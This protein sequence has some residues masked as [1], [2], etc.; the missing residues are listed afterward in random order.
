ML[1]SFYDLEEYFRLKWTEFSSIYVAKFSNVTSR[2]NFYD[3]YCIFFKF[4]SSEKTK[5]YRTIVYY[6]RI[7]YIIQTFS[8]HV[9]RLSIF[10][11]DDTRLRREKRIHSMHQRLTFQRI[12]F[13]HCICIYIYFR[14]NLNHFYI[15]IIIFINYESSYFLWKLLSSILY[16]KFFHRSVD[17]F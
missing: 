2:N 7:M 4:Y 8:L 10:P 5:L 12:I 11:G 9:S 1:K 13:I 6:I 15:K 17:I 14:Y 16:I 3:E